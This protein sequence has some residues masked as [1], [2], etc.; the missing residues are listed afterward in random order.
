M[1]ITRFRHK[2]T[3]KGPQKNRPVKAGMKESVGKKQ[4]RMAAGDNGKLTV[5]EMA[6]KEL[7]RPQW[8]WGFVRGDNKG[9]NRKG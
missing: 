3:G 6:A 7:R 8:L 2:D 4:E 1:K 5:H 9:I